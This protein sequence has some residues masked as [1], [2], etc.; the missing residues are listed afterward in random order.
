LEG[1]IPSPRR[2]APSVLLAGGR[3]GSNVATLTAPIASFSVVWPTIGHPLPRARDA[4]AES[5]KWA[6]ILGPHGHGP[7]WRRVFAIDEPHVERLWTAIAAA[8]ISSPV[9]RLRPGP[10]GVGCDIRPILTFNDRTARVLIAWHY[11]EPDAAPRLVTA[12][13]TP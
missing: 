6:W 11:A 12:Y 1:S 10:W 2:G 7:H 9:A 8:T 5:I 4:Y 13:P 3:T